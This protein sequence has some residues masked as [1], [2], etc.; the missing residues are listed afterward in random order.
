MMRNSDTQSN[1]SSFELKITA[2]HKHLYRVSL[3]VHKILRNSGK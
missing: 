3:D 2:E 1:E